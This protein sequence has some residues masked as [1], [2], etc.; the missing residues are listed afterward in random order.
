MESKKK[1]LL[2]HQGEV[3]PQTNATA[4][5]TKDVTDRKSGH[6]HERYPHKGTQSG[7]TAH[8]VH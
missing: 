2:G 7:K 1:I 4:P 5:Q 8:D 6:W 3:D